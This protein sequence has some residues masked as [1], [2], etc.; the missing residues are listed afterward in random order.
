MW[1]SV[2]IITSNER[3]DILMEKDGMIFARN[4]KNLRHY[5]KLTMEQFADK[6][7]VQRQT[8]STSQ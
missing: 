6:I 2:T 8:V 7:Y 4:L 1:H 5:L 3:E